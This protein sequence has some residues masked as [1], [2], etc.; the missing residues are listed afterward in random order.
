MVVRWS[1][2]LCVFP[3]Q[4]ER[5]GDSDEE[6]GPY[7]TY[8]QVREAQASNQEESRCDDEQRSGDDTV[9]RAIPQPV[10]YATDSC[11]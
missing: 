7:Q 4:Q 3:F 6:Q 8:V 2:T 9:K 11:G 5:Y 1:R 10:G